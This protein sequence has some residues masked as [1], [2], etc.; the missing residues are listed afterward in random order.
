MPLRTDIELLLEQYFDTCYQL[1]K[2]CGVIIND[3]IHKAKNVQTKSS[4]IDL[5]TETDQ[6]V[7]KRLISGL[8]R[9]FP[10]HKFIGEESASASTERNKLT[11]DPTWIIDP[12][13]GTTNFVHGFPLVCISVGLLIDKVPV[14]GIIYNPVLDQMF[15]AKK[16]KGSFMNGQKINVSRQT[17]ISNSLICTE[18]GS[19]KDPEWCRVVLNNL[20]NLIGAVQGLRAVGTAA[21][22]ICQV[23]AGSLD[24]FCH[25]GLHCWDTAAGQ[26]IVTEAGGIM[27]DYGGGP[28]DLMSRRVICASSEKLGKSMADLLEAVELERD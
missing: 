5:V 13:D 18:T 21:W 14:I 24:G 15:T 11:S 6:E 7:E 2:E 22:A 12:V 19:N 28:F 9:K 26:V 3:A 8:K 1:V 16:G 17:E 20:A 10:T 27:M 4:D 23:A 25:F